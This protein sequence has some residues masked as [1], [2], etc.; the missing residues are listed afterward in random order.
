MSKYVAK[1]FHPVNGSQEDV[2][3]GFSWPCL[4][5]GCFWFAAKG[6]WGW[7]VLSFLVAVPSFGVSWF[8]FPFFANVLHASSLRKQGYLTE[9]EWHAKKTGGSTQERSE[10]SSVADELAKLSAL[11]KQG[12]LTET[13]FRSQKAK[14]IGT[15]PVQQAPAERPLKAE[16]V[17]PI[18]NPTTPCPMCRKQIRIAWLK[19][20]E[21]ICPH[22]GGKIIGE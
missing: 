18:D 7:T 4:F 3:E 17:P 5:L 21:N 15:P 2:W 1:A 22:C 11:M 10:P 8:I 20:G 12:V 14:L 6:M 13:E 9:K 16:A 19:V